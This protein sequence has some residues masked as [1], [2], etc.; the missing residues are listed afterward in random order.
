VQSEYDKNKGGNN[1][2][3]FLLWLYNGRKKDAR[4]NGPQEK[5]I[6]QRVLVSF[7]AVPN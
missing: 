6:S 3:S 4:G 7:N 2:K 5:G 1:N